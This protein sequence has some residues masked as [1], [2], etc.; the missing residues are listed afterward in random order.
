MHMWF[1][2]A[3]RKFMLRRDS[4]LGLTLRLFE[5]PFCY[6][7]QLGLLR[8]SIGAHLKSLPTV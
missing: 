7:G 8:Y 4:L 1:S 6:R 5:K 2:I 3:L